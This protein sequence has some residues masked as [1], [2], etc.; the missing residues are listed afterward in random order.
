MLSFLCSL[1][2]YCTLSEMTTIKMINQSLTDKQSNDGDHKIVAVG[3]G[4]DILIWKITIK[5]PSLF[6]WNSSVIYAEHNHR[7]LRPCF[8][9]FYC[10]I[11]RMPV[12]RST[13]RWNGFGIKQFLTP[14]LENMSLF[15]GAQ[16][17]D[18][19][20]APF[21]CDIN[22]LLFCKA[23]WVVFIRR[24]LFGI[25]ADPR[26]L[27]RIEPTHP[28]FNVCFDAG[29][30]AWKSWLYCFK[31]FLVSSSMIA[32]GLLEHPHPEEIRGMCLLTKAY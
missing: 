30:K 19:L 29:M 13:T 27:L 9:Y 32:T 18:T 7:P 20:R 6:R 4:N 3:G 22:T 8:L 23:V 14:N 28:S 2:F 1:Y 10:D 24:V 16:M 15:Y 21:Q 17:R 11:A 5:T 12:Q 31:G 25:E 26:V